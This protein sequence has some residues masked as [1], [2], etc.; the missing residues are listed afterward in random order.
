M[1]KK[2]FILLSNPFILVTLHNFDILATERLNRTTV[3]FIYL[4][5]FI[6]V[7]TSPVDKGCNKMR[8]SFE[9]FSVESDV[10]LASMYTDF[11][12]KNR[13]RQKPILL[14]SRN[15]VSSLHFH[16]KNSH[17]DCLTFPKR[18]SVPFL[19]ELPAHFA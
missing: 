15:R 1:E 6:L 3:L 2:A 19:D 16:S 12:S 9:P 14:F 4:F 10:P 7:N 11:H 17:K 13:L 18:F 5:M 8:F